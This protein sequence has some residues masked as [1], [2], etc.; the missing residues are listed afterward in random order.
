MRLNNERRDLLCPWLNPGRYACWVRLAGIEE[1]KKGEHNMTAKEEIK[2]QLLA[3]LLRS[4]NVTDEIIF[5]LNLLGFFVTENGG[6]IQ[7]RK[8]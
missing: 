2:F 5:Q 6:I 4:K 1:I 3:R 8:K 7:K